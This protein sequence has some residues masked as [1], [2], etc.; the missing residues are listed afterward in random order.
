[1]LSK[2]VNILQPDRLLQNRYFRIGLVYLV[3]LLY[4]V[5]LGYFISKDK[6]I[7]AAVPAGLL[8][9]F[10]ALYRLELIFWF[11][12]FTIPLSVPLKEFSSGLDF[13]M[14]LPTEPL[15]AG[16]LVI[17]LI[18][19]AIDGSFDRKVLKHPVTI[20]ILLQLV[21]LLAT[22]ITSTMPGISL[23]FFLSRL[24]FVAVFYFIATQVFKDLHKIGRYFWIMLI[25]MAAV[26]IL[27]TL[28]H[29]GLGLFDQKAANPAVDP[30]FNDHTL[31]GAIMALFIP[32]A[33]GY[34]FKSDF[35]WW[36]RIG[37]F[38]VLCL[39]VTGLIFSYS[40]AAWVSLA[41]AVLVYLILLFKIPWKTVLLGV[42][43]LVVAIMLFGKVLIM[44]MEGNDQDSSD[45][46]MEHVQSISN[47]STDA[48]NLERLN[49]WNCA[50]RMFAEKPFFGFGPGTYMFQYAPFQ[51]ESQKTIISTNAADG[52]N[53]HSEYLGPLSESGLFGGLLVLLL[54]VYGFITGVRVYKR[55]TD[56]ELKMVAVVVIIGLTTYF[57]HGILNNFLDTDKA[58]AGVWAFLAILVALDVRKDRQKE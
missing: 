56:R 48:S 7:M 46:F 26:I 45:N 58:S 43:G 27:I 25:P 5:V 38:I 32:V 2:I 39:L 44:N 50:L 6:Y 37:A 57:L 15:L 35:N 53:A 42:A 18:K 34:I 40:R 49:R 36:Q 30:F 19:L 52:G 4:V 14:F 41:G 51:K 11:I 21:W 12:L 24:W 17:F 23:K 29:I 31:Y 1:M 10:V 54:V 47:I 13:N 16:L 22:S 8:L 9:A 3:S 28:K 55:E 33:I 20:I